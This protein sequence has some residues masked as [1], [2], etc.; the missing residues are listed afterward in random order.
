MAANIVTEPDAGVH[1][2]VEAFHDPA[3]PD[4]AVADDPS[5]QFDGPVID[6]APV[7]DAP[8]VDD[9]SHPAPE[10]HHHLETDSGF[11]IFD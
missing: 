11:D 5:L 1:P 3:V 10:D 9:W 4:M 7:H 6:D 2:G 8:P